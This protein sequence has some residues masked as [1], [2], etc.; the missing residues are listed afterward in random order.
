MSN[1]TGQ[2]RSLTDKSETYAVIDRQITRAYND[3]SEFSKREEITF[4][5]G[6]HSLAVHEVVESMHDRCLI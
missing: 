6:A 3:V 1:E 4:R 2:V 5:I